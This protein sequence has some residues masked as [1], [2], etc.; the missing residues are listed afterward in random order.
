MLR[1]FFA[2]CV[3]SGLM[4]FVIQPAF[5]QTTSL[6]GNWQLTLVANGTTTSV[7]GLANFTSD[8]EAIATAGAILAGPIGTSNTNPLTPAFGSWCAGGAVGNFE[9]AFLSYVT[10]PGGSLYATRNF[11]AMG[12]FMSA[13]QFQGTY[14]VQTTIGT[15]TSLSEGTISGTL[16]P[17]II[18]PPSS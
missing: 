18:C 16:I 15:I 5:A 8:G 10:N 2:A 12:R 14:Q 17:N 7:V 4:A 1:K 11:S 6:A 3:L 13:S 9:I